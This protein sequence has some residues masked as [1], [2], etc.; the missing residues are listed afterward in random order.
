MLHVNPGIDIGKGYLN[1]GMEGR[2]FLMNHNTS[3]DEQLLNLHPDPK[4]LRLII[5]KMEAYHLSIFSDDEI[6]RYNRLSQFGQ[7]TDISML[8]LL[9]TTP[10][11][12]IDRLNE[13]RDPLN[14]EQI[15]I[16]KS[17]TLCLTLIG[18]AVD[19]PHDSLAKA[20]FIS[21]DGDLMIPA[22]YMRERMDVADHFG[23]PT[24]KNSGFSGSFATH[25]LRDGNHAVALYIVSRDGAGYYQSDALHITVIS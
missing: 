1:Q 22:W 15:I 19:A 17:E 7:G 4:S 13:I 18:W 10:H 3:C 24:L 5:P 2:F 12:S 11:Y 23:D 20:V 25:L 9:S 8:P 21:V 16:N 6:E 14:Q